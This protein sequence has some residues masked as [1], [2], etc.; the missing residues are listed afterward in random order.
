MLIQAIATARGQRLVYERPTQIRG[1]ACTEV[2]L[3]G[4]VAHAY[5]YTIGYT[6]VLVLAHNTWQHSPEYTGKRG[7]EAPLGCA[8]Y[9]DK[10]CLT[11]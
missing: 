1:W 2:S 5:G 4:G 7:G 6:M 11:H 9:R 10:A 8:I 3:E